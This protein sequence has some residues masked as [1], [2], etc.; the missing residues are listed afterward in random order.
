MTSFKIRPL[1]EAEVPILEDFLYETIFQADL[2]QPLPRSILQKPELSVY[3]DD[4]GRIGDFCL[5]T[6]LGNRVVGAIWTRIFSGAIRGF[7]TIEAGTPELAMSVLEPYRKKGIGTALLTAMLAKLA[8]AGYRQVSL[9]VQKSNYAVRMYQKAG[10]QVLKDGDDD[11]IM[12]LRLEKAS[13]Y[14]GFNP[15]KK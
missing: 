5:V 10:F 13:K 11:L 6:K 15:L 1:K 2:P 14:I 7:G 9:S 8:K 12:V 3:I 4:F